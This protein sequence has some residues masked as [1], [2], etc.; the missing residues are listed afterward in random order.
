MYCSGT[1]LVRTEHLVPHDQIIVDS[2]THMDAWHNWH[3]VEYN[4]VHARTNVIHAYIYTM[5]GFISQG[6]L[7]QNYVQSLCD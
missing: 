2:H 7:V 5:H 1:M 6:K 3:C 4:A